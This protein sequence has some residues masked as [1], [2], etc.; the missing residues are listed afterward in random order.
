MTLSSGTPYIYRVS[1]LSHSL[2]RIHAAWQVIAPAAEYGTDFAAGAG[3][4]TEVYLWRV[5]PAASGPTTDDAATLLRGGKRQRSGAGA[6][7]SSF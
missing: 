7:R 6:R 3:T 1:V 4:H 2:H 5:G